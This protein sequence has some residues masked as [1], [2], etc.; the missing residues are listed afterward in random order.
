MH[1]RL[2]ACTVIDIKYSIWKVIPSHDLTDFPRRFGDGWDHYL[3]PKTLAGTTDQWREQQWSSSLC[4][5][6]RVNSMLPCIYLL[7]YR[8]K[9]VVVGFVNIRTHA[10][11]V[12]NKCTLYLIYDIVYAEGGRGNGRISCQCG[13]GW[14]RYSWLIGVYSTT[15]NKNGNVINDFHCK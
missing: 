8:S 6:T 2:R 13:R 5:A 3:A 9:I 15:E 1:I 7:R 11:D 10:I 4:R 14:G 12:T